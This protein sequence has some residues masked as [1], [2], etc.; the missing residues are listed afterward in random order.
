MGKAACGQQGE[1]QM[2]CY[3]NGK[4]SG[5]MFLGGFNL[6]TQGSGSIGKARGCLPMGLRVPCA[7]SELVALLFAAP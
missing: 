2:G 3:D 1:V 4:I 7:S 6:G 5:W